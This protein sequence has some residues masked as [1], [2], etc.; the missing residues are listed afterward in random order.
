MSDIETLRIKLAENVS[1]LPED[2][3]QKAFDFIA[4]LLGSNGAN[5]Q[6]QDYPSGRDPLLD[7]IGGVSH[8]S[9]SANIDD[10][11]YGE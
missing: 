3:L 8:G 9:L 11:L 2:K 6:L 5:Y 7:Y 10:D 1:H 4:S